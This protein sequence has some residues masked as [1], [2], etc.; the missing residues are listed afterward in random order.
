MLR[1]LNIILVCSVVGVAVWL[2]QLKY[3]VRD[4]MMEVAALE[5]QIAR[6]KQDLTLLKAEWSHVARPKRVQDLAKRHLE[7]EGVRPSQIIEE[8]AIATTIPDREPVEPVYPG[9]DPIAGLLRIDQ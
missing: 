3:G 5:R 8:S 7:L 6:A 2:Y 4:K 1:V 9:D